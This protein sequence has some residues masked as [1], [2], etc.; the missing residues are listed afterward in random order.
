MQEL[1]SLAC[2]CSTCRG[3]RP[4]GEG[5]RLALSW[6]WLPGAPLL[7]AVNSVHAPT[8]LGTRHPVVV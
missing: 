8:P 5:A 2:G 1:K 6:G 4:K 7:W 3:R